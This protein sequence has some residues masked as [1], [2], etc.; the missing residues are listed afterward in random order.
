MIRR[1]ARADIPSHAGLR[2]QN[3]GKG[4]GRNQYAS[5]P[6][7]AVARRCLCT[8]GSTRWMVLMFNTTDCWSGQDASACVCSFGVGWL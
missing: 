6:P 8:P 5:T 7:A 2:A 1:K 3:R 4:V